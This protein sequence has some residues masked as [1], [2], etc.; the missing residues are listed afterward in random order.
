M[1]WKYGVLIGA[2]QD[3]FVF[4]NKN[5]AFWSKI[6]AILL[7]MTYGHDKCK[8]HKHAK[9]FCKAKKWET[10]VSNNFKVKGQSPPCSSCKGLYKFVCKYTL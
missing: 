2:A 9:I 10:Y 5:N 3:R 1:E 7:H 6:D 4:I 8:K